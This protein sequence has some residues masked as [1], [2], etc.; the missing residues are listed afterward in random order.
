MSEYN[1]QINQLKKE[2]EELRQARDLAEKNYHILMNDNNALNIKLDNLE[3]V[4]IGNPV[5]KGE[6]QS[7]SR[8]KAEDDFMIS[9]VNILILST[10]TN[11]K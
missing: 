10:L 9:N 6:A 11:P 4:F 2:N 5:S 1:Y 7:K 3:N 8:T